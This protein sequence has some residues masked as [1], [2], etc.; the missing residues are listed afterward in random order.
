MLLRD[1]WNLLS[2]GQFDPMNQMLSLTVIPLSGAHC[3]SVVNQQEKV[4]E[5]H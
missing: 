5:N 4:T 3:I 2:L 1:V